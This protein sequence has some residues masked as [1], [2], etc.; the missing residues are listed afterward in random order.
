[1][2][3]LGLLKVSLSFSLFIWLS[4]CDSRRQHDSF[5]SIEDANWFIEQA[6]V[7]ETE[8]S[9][10]GSSYNMMINVRNNK[11]YSYSNLYIFIETT[12][13]GGSVQQDT[14]QCILADDKG[15]WLGRGIGGILTSRIPFRSNFKFPVAGVYKFK[16]SHGMRDNPLTG[17]TDAGIRIEK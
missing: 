9:D 15:K 6:L 14:A 16:L 10:T 3:R 5:Q 1:M 2:H 11:D 17:I 8:V 7:F 13:P 12:I 4:A